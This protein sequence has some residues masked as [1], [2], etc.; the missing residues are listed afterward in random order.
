MKLPFIICCLLGV[1]FKGDLSAQSKFCDELVHVGDTFICRDFI[2]RGIAPARE[3]YYV[4]GR[5]VFTR[6]WYYLENGMYY[7]MQFRSRWKY[8]RKHGPSCSYYEDGTPMV[9][10]VY[11]NG[12]RAKKSP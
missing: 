8:A 10:T 12:N 9:S 1:F 7:F 6:R 5:M 3:H 11:D 4:Y 2:G